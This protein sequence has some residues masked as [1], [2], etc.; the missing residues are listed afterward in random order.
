M[1]SIIIINIMKCIHAMLF[2]IIEIEILSKNKALNIIIIN[3][4]LVYLRM[5]G[6]GGETASLFAENL[7]LPEYPV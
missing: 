6:V 1:I 5:K 2:R 3:F 4:I 7:N